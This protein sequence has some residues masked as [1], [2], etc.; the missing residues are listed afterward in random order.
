M[1]GMNADRWIYSNDENKK[2]GKNE[3]RTQNSV[4]KATTNNNTPQY[5]FNRV[6]DVCIPTKLYYVVLHRIV[7]LRFTSKPFEC[8]ILTG[9]S[10]RSEKLTNALRLPKRDVR[11]CACAS[12]CWCACTSV[13]SFNSYEKVQFSH[14][15]SLLL[16]SVYVPVCAMCN[17]VYVSTNVSGVRNVCVSL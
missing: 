5:V 17:F 13:V 6:F 2:I 7:D 4:A 3:T 16:L 15:I 10:K 12:A 1:G 14:S 8:K 11:V 9:N